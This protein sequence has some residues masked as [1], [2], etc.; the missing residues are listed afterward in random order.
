MMFKRGKIFVF[1]L[2]LIIAFLITPIFSPVSASTVVDLE[3]YK[4]SSVEEVNT[5]LYPYGFSA[6]ISPIS[7]FFDNSGNYYVAYDGSKN[8]YI[9]V[10]NKS[11]MKI[12]KTITINKPYPILGGVIGDDKGNFYAFFGQE[13]TA[14]KSDKVTLAVIRYDK[15]GKKI[16]E[17]SLK[18]KDTCTFWDP[19]S[20]SR[21]PFWYGN[22]SMAINGNI[23][24]ISYA[25]QMYNGHQSNFVIYVKIPDLTRIKDLP[26]PYTSHSFDQRIMVA[27]NGDFIFADQG[28]AYPRGFHIQ[29]VK[30][31]H[32][33]IYE[34]YS[35]VPFHFREGSNRDYGYNLTFAS[36]GGIAEISKGY[37]LAGASEKTLSLKTAPTKEYYGHN[38]PRNVFVQIFKKDYEN[39]SEDKRQLLNVPVRKAT[40]KRNTDAK[41][42]MFL[43]PGTQD[44]GVKWLTDYKNYEFAD[45]VKVIANKEDQI[46]I[47]WEK[48]KLDGGSSYS[49]VYLA[50]YYTILNNKGETVVKPTQLKN[51]RLTAYEQ[52][53][54]DGKYLYWTTGATGKKQLTLHRLNV[55]P[56]TEDDIN[57]IKSKEVINLINAISEDKKTFGEDIKKAREAYNK[58]S[59]KQKAL[60]TNYKKLTD[61]E[62]RYAEI[63]AP[64][65]LTVNT[66]SNKD[67][68]ITGKTRANITVK[69]YVNNKQIGSGKA[70]SKG[71]FKITIKK[72][73]ENTTI[74]VTATDD[75]TKVS[76]SKSVKVADK[77]PPEL[78]VPAIHSSTTVIKGKT[79]AKASVKL[80]IKNKHVKT[81]TADSKGNYQF[82]ISKQVSGTEIKITASDNAKN[83]VSKTIKVKPYLSV[84]TVSD[85]STK[86]T[87]KTE[88]KAS[89]NV[90]LNNKLYKT[91]TADKNGKFSA[92]I[93]KQKAGAKVKVVATRNKVSNTV[94]K[95]VADKTPPSLT[96]PA[97][98]SNTTVIKGKTEARTSVKLYIG[99]KHIKTVTADS[100]G[101]YQ[102]KISK[103]SSGTKIRITASDK[104]KNST[105]KTITVKPYLS[106]NTVSD[107]STKVAGKTE[108]KAKVKIYVKNKHYKTVTADKNGKFSVTLK[109]QKPGT[110]VKVVVTKNKLSTTV[111]KTVVDKSPPPLTVPKHVD[112]DTTVIKGKTESKASVKLYINNK[113][114]KTVTA[115][116]KGN[117]QFKISRQSAGTRIKITAS[118]KAKNT[119]TKTVTVWLKM[120]VNTISNKSTK[121][122]G[123]T[124]A[125]ATVK[126]Y[127]N[128]KLFKTV[129]AD[130]NGRFSVPVK[131]QKAGTV[132]RVVATKNK[133]TA[134]YTT[135]VIRR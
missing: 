100:K 107:K 104:A 17:L 35:Y 54:Y 116:S 95:T 58:L 6:D 41:T 16:K 66:V 47:M 21:V 78:S 131:K 110:K 111:T 73:T 60:V 79:E 129:K 56:L 97:V 87:G 117:Y 29:K 74:K 69:A 49:P 37:V 32:S 36:L 83:S 68:S 92:S 42:K 44:Y 130:K 50:T 132:V 33:N 90:Y 5:D 43:E 34:S 59:S 126:V 102:F 108:A 135:R 39:Y 96:V 122:T 82:N 57:R 3:S 125:K 12:I 72:Q 45:N 80:Y 25:R 63:M 10:L 120:S 61:A 113:Y 20:G 91:V 14:G 71:N 1:F 89:V 109:K 22:A 88:A 118:D 84:N 2:A 8:F 106:V 114:V 77:I 67:T 115:D 31:N 40:D 124:D 86:V 26:E 48:F 30:K 76:T 65:P 101:N 134:S 81:V 15:N 85:K 13:D 93:K 53:V 99:N 64:P 127:F 70:D 27:S 105:T 19:D 52:P 121:I 46:V 123:K 24:A 7:E 103:R 23:L 75:K 18:G 28:D 133:C 11:N 38:E 4:F 128:N 112:T 9:A 55:S 51:V 62:A 98:T 94:T 119:T